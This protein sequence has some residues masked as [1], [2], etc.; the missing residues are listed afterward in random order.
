[1]TAVESDLKRLVQNAK[2][3]N[4]DE[5]QIFQD[6]ERIRK[7]VFN[8]MKVNNPAYKEDPNYSAVATAI[9]KPDAKIAIAPTQNGAHVKKSEAEVPVSRQAIEKPKLTATKKSSEPP[10]RKASVAPSATTGD[11]EQDG[12]DDEE[13]G[14]GEIELNL[15]GKTFQEAQQ[16][17]ISHLLRYTDEE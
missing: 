8:F 2:A 7:L 10:D 13:A 1:M 4:D 3:F 15:E 9:P 17:I 14:D 16:A 11:A 5:S 12:D 6:A